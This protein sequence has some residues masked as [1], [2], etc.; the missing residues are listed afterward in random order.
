MDHPGFYERHGPFPA[1]AVADAIGAQLVASDAD[2][3]RLIHDVR[4][5]DEASEHDVSF[6]DNAKYVRHLTGARAGACIVRGELTERVPGGTLALVTSDPY[7]AF[8]RTLALYYPAAL[9]PAVS[10]DFSPGTP[11][12]H[13][14]ARIEEGASISPAAW[15]GPEAMIGR[16]CVISPGAVIGY[17]VTIGR[18]C[19]VGPNASITHALVGNRVIVHG[20][21]QIG[22]DGFGFAM[23]RQGHMKVPQIGRVI[24]Q[25]DVEIGANSTVD[26]GAL[27]DTVIGEGSKIDNLVQIAHNVR[28][29]R[30]CVIVA[31]SGVSGST[32]LGDYVVIGGQSAIAGHLTIGTAAQIAGRSGVTRDVPAHAVYGGFPA[33]PKAEWAR[34]VAALHRLSK[35]R[36]QES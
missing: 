1:H 9:R 13:P 27:K 29:G 34:E 11:S 36:E 22:Q 24:I 16:G 17:R 18:E 5:I 19:Y 25:D 14:S 3:E 21:V 23:G 26:R 15:V 32:V 31:Q 4:A 10:T 35:R 30:H 12:I 28:I 8:A 2:R 6:I 20:G 33:R 7:R